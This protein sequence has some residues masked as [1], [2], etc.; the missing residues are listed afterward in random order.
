MSS[1][2]SYSGTGTVYGAINLAT[3]GNVTFN[4]NGTIGSPFG[5]GSLEVVSSGTN[6]S[7]NSVETAT[8][9]GNTTD[10]NISPNGSSGTHTFTGMSSSTTIENST[11]ATTLN[12]GAV[13]FNNSGTIG[14]NASNPIYVYVNGPAGA[15]ANN[16]GTIYGD[17]EV[18]SDFQYYNN[19]Q[20]G[21]SVESITFGGS[22]STTIVTNYS[23]TKVTSQSSTM[24]NYP[25]LLRIVVLQRRP[26]R[27]QHDSG[28][29]AGRSP[30]S[31]SLHRRRMC[32]SSTAARS[33]S[34]C[35]WKP[36][37]TSDSSA[38]STTNSANVG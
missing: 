22:Q 31:S 30:A 7:F 13:S 20:F 8:R 21:T 3:S 10:A 17:L 1:T 23:G 32:W 33:G 6:F 38:E 15:T 9:S 5:G 37:A 25:V 28:Q 29:F 34:R 4:N 16:S 18:E 19:P 36:M 14:G 27:R 11:S 26:A 2:A 12:G 24:T 35:P